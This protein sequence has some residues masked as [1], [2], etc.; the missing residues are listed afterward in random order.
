MGV[1]PLQYRPGEN[2]KSLGL[3][4]RETFEIAGIAAG[5]TPG[6][7][8]TVRARRDDG[9]EVAFQAILRIDSRIEVD[10]YRNGGVLHTVLRQMLSESKS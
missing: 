8:L 5:L 2:R 6:Q 7:E 4:G 3:T 10:Y 1:L 9:T